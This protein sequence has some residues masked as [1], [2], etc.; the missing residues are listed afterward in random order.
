MLTTRLSYPMSSIIFTLSNALS[1]NPSAVTFPYFSTIFFSKEPL[2][3][4]TR[5]GTLYSFALSTTAFTLSAEPILPGLILILS[6]PFS[7]AAIAIR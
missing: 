2:F 7:M 3:T 4:P 5:I 1:T 6:A